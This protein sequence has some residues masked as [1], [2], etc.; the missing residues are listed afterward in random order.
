[1]A[2]SASRKRPAALLFDVFGTVVDWRGSVS[3]GVARLGRSH[4]VRA[5]W[6]R[7]ADAGAP[8]IVRRWIGCVAV[9][10]RG[11]RSTACI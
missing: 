8:A 4:G 7:F 10:C 1:M 11:S 9:N 6:A 3:R 2:R 5:D